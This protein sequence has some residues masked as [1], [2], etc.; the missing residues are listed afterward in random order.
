MWLERRIPLLIVFFMGVLM[1]LQYFFTH[2]ISQRIYEVTIDWYLGVIGLSIIMGVASIIR[3]HIVR[4]RQGKETFYSIVTLTSL[5][6]M[7]V[8][9]LFFGRGEGSIFQ[10]LYRNIQV[11][12]DATMFSL[13]AFYIASAAYRA[14]RARTLEATLLLLAAFI[15]IFGMTPFANYIK[16]FPEFTQWILDVPNVAQK[17][18]ITLGVGLGVTATS[19]R[20]IFGIERNWL[21]GGK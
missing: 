3:R 8:S 20:I 19:L 18:G 5:F 11:P 14:F 17:R 6:V 2:P 4:I 10:L 1:T 16:G 9:G 15:L 7:M 13:L 12:L 21:G